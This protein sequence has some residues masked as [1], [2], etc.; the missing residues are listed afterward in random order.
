MARCSVR[1]AVIVS[2]SCWSADSKAPRTPITGREDR[3]PTLK[4]TAIETF[5]IRIPYRRNHTLSSGPLYGA[6]SVIVRVQTDEGLVGAG[7]EI[8]KLVVASTNKFQAAFLSWLGRC[9]A[10]PWLSM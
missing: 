6:H 8:F 3:G 10:A 1:D 4:I 2:P 9:G 7:A 5:E